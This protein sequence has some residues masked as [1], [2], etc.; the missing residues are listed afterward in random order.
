MSGSM[1]YF[2]FQIFP[3]IAI[4]VFLLGSILRF[5]R[6]PYS[7]RSKSS[8]LLRRRQLVVGSILFHLGILLILV[9]HAVGLLTPIAVFDALG[10]SHGAKQILAI[11]AGGGAGIICFIGLVMLLHRRLT[12]PRI[13]A[14]S[15]FADIAVLVLLLAQLSLGLLTIPFS[16]QHLDG[17]EMVKFMGWAQHIVTF[18]GG[19]HELIAD[20]AL[21]FKAHITLGLFLLLVFPFTRLVHA[22]SAPLGYL[23]RPYQIVRKRAT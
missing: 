4:S 8:Q 12:D 3:Y 16:M 13:R 1:D 7:W 6:D 14:N 22:L 23:A 9:G 21:V 19:A 20:V 10:I 15:S 18:R 2:L 5:D 17:H 11:V